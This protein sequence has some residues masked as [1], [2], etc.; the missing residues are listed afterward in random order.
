[1]KKFELSVVSSE[2]CSIITLYRG[3][4][5][6]HPTTPEGDADGGHEGS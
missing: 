6:S 1:M 4:K 5:G 3:G 2:N